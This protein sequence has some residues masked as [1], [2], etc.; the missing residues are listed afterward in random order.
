[1]IEDTEGNM[2]FEKDQISKVIVEYFQRLF[3]SV[4]GVRAETVNYALSPLVTEEDNEAL[5]SIP[6]PAEI[7]EAAFSLSTQTKPLARMAFLRAFSIQT[8]RL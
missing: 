2:V 8:G 1:M 7:R 4:D 6:S 5:I 3:S